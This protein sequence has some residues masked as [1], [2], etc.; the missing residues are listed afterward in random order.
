MSRRTSR[1]ATGPSV[2]DMQLGEVL[3][4]VLSPGAWRH[5]DP[6]VRLGRATDWDELPD[7]SFMP[8]GQK[9]LRIDGE[10]VPLLEIRELV[11]TPSDAPPA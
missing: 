10:P 1:I 11:L 7:G 3:L 8:A 4:P 5:A 9:L 6:E 2:R